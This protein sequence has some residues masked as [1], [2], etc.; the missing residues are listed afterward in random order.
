ML[1]PSLRDLVLNTAEPFIQAIVDLA[2]PR[3][4]AGRTVLVGDAAFVPRPHTAGGA[5]RAAANAMSLA[6]ALRA[7]TE[8][9]ARCLAEWEAGQLRLGRSLVANGVALGQRIMG[10]SP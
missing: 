6:Q 4:V 5:A 1:A 10:P 7:G 8:D 2:T 9:I 3:M